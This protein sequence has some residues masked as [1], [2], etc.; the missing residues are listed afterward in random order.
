MLTKNISW[1]KNWRYFDWPFRVLKNGISK[2]WKKYQNPKD[3]RILVLFQICEIPIWS[4]LT[5]HVKCG[6]F[7]RPG[8]H[9]DPHSH[10]WKKLREFTWL[11]S[12]LTSGILQ[13]RKKCQ[14]P[15]ILRI[16]T[17][18]SDLQNSTCMYPYGPWE[19]LPFLPLRRSHRNPHSYR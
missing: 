7:C 12:V 9:K 1:C 14:N 19:V 17:L 18:Y 2:I 11:V 16:L 5:G 10:G 6:H 8:A 3:L 4:T 13:I 15:D